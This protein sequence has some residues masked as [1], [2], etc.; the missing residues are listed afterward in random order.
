MMKQSVDATYED[1]RKRELLAEL[2]LRILEVQCSAP[3]MWIAPSHT[4]SQGFSMVISHFPPYTTPAISAN[5]DTSPTCKSS[6]LSLCVLKIIVL[7]CCHFSHPIVSLGLPSPL[8]ENLKTA[9]A[10]TKSISEQKAQ[11]FT[12][13]YLDARPNWFWYHRLERFSQVVSNSV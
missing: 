2:Q 4:I 11:Q 6:Q 12:Y 3:V 1:I 8:H 10:A 5:E 7:P 9:S 13:S